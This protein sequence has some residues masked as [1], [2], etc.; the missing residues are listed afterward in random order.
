[1]IA[2]LAAAGDRAVALGVMGRGTGAILADLVKSGSCSGVLAVGG[3]GGTSVAVRAFSRLP[4][5]FPKMIVSTQ[6]AAAGGALAGGSDVLLI[7]RPSPTSQ[8]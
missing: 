6:V 1:M 2:D 7:C 4:F 8:A 5:G 3:S